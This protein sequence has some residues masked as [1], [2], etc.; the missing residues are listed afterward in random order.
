[1]RKIILKKIC[2]LYCVVSLNSVLFETLFVSFQLKV[3]SLVSDVTGLTL[4]VLDIGDGFAIT[5]LISYPVIRCSSL[6]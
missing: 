5:A 1:M 2:I 3:K 6:Y 4:T